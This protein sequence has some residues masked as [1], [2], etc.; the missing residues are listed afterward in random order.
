MDP[1]LQCPKP[2]FSLGFVRF[3][4]EAFPVFYLKGICLAAT[5]L[6]AKYRKQA[7]PR[8]SVLIMYIFTPSHFQCNIRALASANALPLSSRCSLFL[9]ALPRCERDSC[10][11][12]LGGNLM[13]CFLNRLS[14][15]PLFLSPS[16][17]PNSRDI[18][19]LNS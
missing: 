9:S 10:H 11:T 5:I 7:G 16:L 6:V 15:N 17:T 8:V 13:V 19:C 2:F 12:H 4:G 3:P 1:W 14:N 18:W